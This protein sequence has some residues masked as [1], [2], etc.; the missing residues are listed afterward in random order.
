MLGAVDVA[1]QRKPLARVDDDALDLKAGPVANRLVGSPWP[2][3]LRRQNGM[4]GFVPLEFFDEFSGFGD[5]LHRCD[6][7]C[8]ANS[9]YRHLFKA[10][11]GY[12]PA[13]VGAQQGVARVEGDN[14]ALD[15][16]IVGVLCSKLP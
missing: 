5:S 8:V 13:T 1:L 4:V 16:I 10:D 3:D 15:N 6:E 12:E 11:S 14:F 9:D 2:S 7:D